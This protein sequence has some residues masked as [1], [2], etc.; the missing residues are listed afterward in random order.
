M[1][2]SALKTAVATFGLLA[3]VIARHSIVDTSLVSFGVAAAVG[4][5]S[6]A[7]YMLMQEAHGPM[8][9]DMQY[10]ALFA[11]P[12]SAPGAAKAA[13]APDEPSLT[14][15]ANVDMTPTGSIDRHENRIVEGGG[16][17][18][19]G[20]R[21]DVVYLSSGDR[22]EAVRV[23]DTIQGRGEVASI[24]WRNGSWQLLDSS[25]R[26]LLAEAGSGA[27]NAAS[28]RFSRDMIF[29]R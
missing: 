8:V 2:R 18:I 12:R 26:M 29:G 11:Q 28:S 14:K 4:S 27:K 1:I 22:I 7:A 19:V 5:T 9:N 6:F 25:G 13:P 10:L 17:R 24:A 15:F 21:A 3:G 23:G 20:G 16:L